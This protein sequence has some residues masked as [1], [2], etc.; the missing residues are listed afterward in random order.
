MIGIF[1]ILNDIF[2]IYLFYQLK[3]A[4][5]SNSFLFN[6]MSMQNSCFINSCYY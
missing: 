2:F 4:K 3:R 6:N 1:R 5:P